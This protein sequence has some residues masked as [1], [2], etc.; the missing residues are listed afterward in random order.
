LKLLAMRGLPRFGVLAVLSAGILLGGCAMPRM[1]DS[2]VQRFA[3]SVPATTPA[4]YRFERLP[5]QAGRTS[6]DQ[7]EAI[8]EPVLLQVGLSR[9]DVATYTVEVS[10]DVQN[11]DNPNTTRRRSNPVFGGVNVGVGFGTEGTGLGF[12]MNLEPP[13]YQNTVRVLVRDVKSGQVAFESRAVHVGPWTD[14]ANLLG[15]VL[16]AAMRGYPQPSNGL[17]REVIELPARQKD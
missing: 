4:T 15:P 1:V 11:F 9:S 14:T 10:L 2:D 7:I 6:Q 16:E 3:G 12:M 5:S 17:V 13:W 8:A